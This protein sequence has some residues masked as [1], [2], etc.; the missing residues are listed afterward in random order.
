LRKEHT[1]LEV[2]FETQKRELTIAR[3][4]RKSLDIG[5]ITPLFDSVCFTVNLVN[6][7]QLDILASLRESVNEDKA[8]MEAD[9]SRLKNQI[10]ELSDKNKMQLEQ[11]NELLLEKVNLQSDGIGQREKMLQ[12][13][14]AF[15]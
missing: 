9:M 11:V 13:E 2:A 3:S 14:R 6:K 1:E 8:G 4:D 12:R 7:D 10:K 15:G 5:G